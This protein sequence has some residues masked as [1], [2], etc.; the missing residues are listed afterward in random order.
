MSRRAGSPPD[1]PGFEFVEVLGTGG[2]ADVFG[3][4]QLGLGRDVAVKVLLGDAAA[5]AGFDAE[6]TVMAQLSNHP[7]IVSIFQAGLTTDGR[8]FLVMEYCPPPHLGLRVRM[9]PLTPA[10]A[11]EITI[12]LAGAVETAHRMGILHRDIKPANVLST[13]FGRAA[14][15]DF[16]ISVNT[17]SA[18]SGGGMSVPWSPPEQLAE[19]APMGPASDVWSLAATMWT[20]LVG[21]SPFHLADEPNDAITMAGRVRGRELPTTG[22]RD[23]PESLERVLRTA[24]AKRP[25]DRFETALSFARALQAVQVEL[26]LPMTTIDV[27]DQ[28]PHS[29]VH[30]ASGATRVTMFTP[31]APQTQA[32]P[33][34]PGPSAW[35]GT[36]PGAVPAAADLGAP[37]GHRLA[38]GGQ[39]S[40]TPP[41]EPSPAWAGPAPFPQAPFQP[42]SPQPGALQF[43]AP[44]PGHGPPDQV[45]WPPAAGRSVL[46]GPLLWVLLVLLIV[47]LGVGIGAGLAAVAAPSPDP[48]RGGQLHIEGSDVTASGPDTRHISDSTPIVVRLPGVFGTD[49]EGT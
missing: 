36:D 34:Q 31:M 22:R 35:G 26:H 28:H 17:T 27:I 48:E 49:T 18:A 5:H 1:V 29:F 6:A 15:T 11:L 3:Y 44:Q 20:A 30:D 7:S 2:S 37:P 46:R 10:K 23:V 9:R 42:S 19:G 40:P 8:P 25:E 14:L 21:H 43:G 33:Q 39:T 12:Q 41:S 13:Q 4:R 32:P 47:G 16:G 24:M 45:P 38:P